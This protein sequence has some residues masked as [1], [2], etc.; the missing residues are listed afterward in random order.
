MCLCCKIILSIRRTL[1]KHVMTTLQ[2][3]ILNCFWCLRAR[4]LGREH[5]KQKVITGRD[6]KVCPHL[7]KLKRSVNT[8]Q[9]SEIKARVEKDLRNLIPLRSLAL[10]Q[11]HLR[12][13]PK[14]KAAQSGA[15]VVHDIFNVEDRQEKSMTVPHEFR[16]WRAPVEWGK[17]GVMCRRRYLRRSAIARRLR[18]R[19]R[20]TRLATI[21]STRTTGWKAYSQWHRHREAFVRG[22]TRKVNCWENFFLFISPF[23]EENSIFVKK[24]TKLIFE[25]RNFLIKSRQVI[26]SDNSILHANLLASMRWSEFISFVAFLSSAWN[27]F[28]TVTRTN[29]APVTSLPNEL[30]QAC[31]E[32]RAIY[33]SSLLTRFGGNR[34]RKISQKSA[35]DSTV[36]PSENSR[37]A[38][39]CCYVWQCGMTPSSQKL[40]N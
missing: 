2:L 7:P 33:A 15:R 24:R 34:W 36:S 35:S 1:R 6:E 28:P 23:C 27:D 21:F 3:L 9:R 32:R 14:R 19:L 22:A 12:T 11:T 20:K 39:E 38:H 5:I 29:L 26:E 13:Q 18:G 8:H 31:S 40:R 37:V 4:R 25:R 17:R 16:W 30:H 10:S